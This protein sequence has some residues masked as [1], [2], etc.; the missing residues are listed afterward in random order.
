MC[1]MLLDSKDLTEKEGAGKG[2]KSEYPK[3]AD[4]VVTA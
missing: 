3:C 4:G 2:R 1:L